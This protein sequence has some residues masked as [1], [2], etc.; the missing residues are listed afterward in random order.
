MPMCKCGAA[1]ASLG[2]RALGRNSAVQKA[3]TLD[4]LISNRPRVLKR[5][6]AKSHDTTT[7]AQHHTRCHP[8]TRARELRLVRERESASAMLTR[9]RPPRPFPVTSKSVTKS[10]DLTLFLTPR[11]SACYPSGRA[12]P[13]RRVGGLTRCVGCGNTDRRGTSGRAHGRRGKGTSRCSGGHTHT[14]V[15]G[16]RARARRRRTAAT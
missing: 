12:R 11:A 1:R 14:G 8:M 13:R 7:R 4:A 3:E 15:R 2:R 6:M 16:T 5:L 9:A 10:S